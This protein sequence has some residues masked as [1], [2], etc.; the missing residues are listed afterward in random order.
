[1]QPLCVFQSYECARWVLISITKATK[2]RII[3]ACKRMHMINAQS[4]TMVF[5]QDAKRGEYVEF[6]RYCGTDF[7]LACALPKKRH[8][9]WQENQ[10]QNCGEFYSQQT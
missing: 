1:M 4:C 2:I 5:S 3:F 7:L 8:T 9:I 10:Q 6:A